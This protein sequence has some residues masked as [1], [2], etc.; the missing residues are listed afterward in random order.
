MLP[1]IREIFAEKHEADFAYSVGGV[2]RFRI[3]AFY[4]RGS[5]ALA[6]RRVRTSASSIED[7]GLP[8]VVR[9]L[10]DEQRGLV[11]VTG[12]TG[13]GKTTTLA[14]M[15]NHINQTRSCHIITV[16]DPIE[17]LHM[18]S[19]ADH[20]P[21]GGRIRH[22]VVHQCHARHSQAGSRRHPGRRDA[23][24]RDRVH[25]IDGCRDRAPRV[26]D[27]AHHHG[28]GDGQPDRRL[29]PAASAPSDPL[30]LGQRV[31]RHYLPEAHPRAWTGRVG[32]RLSRSWW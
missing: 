7:L 13:S 18:D 32:S 8:D 19:T 23:R 21:A 6:V 27:I 12:P 28:D 3:N 31:D 11:L 29:L 1:N 17:Y 15:I 24:P 25:S 26:L 9:R 14:A 22:R 10:A 2:G 16:E 20:R 5:V 30:E 4:Q